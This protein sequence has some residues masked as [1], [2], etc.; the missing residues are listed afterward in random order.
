MW[1]QLLLPRRAVLPGR[2]SCATPPIFIL[3]STGLF[4]KSRM[5][6]RECLPGFLANRISSR[7]G[8]LCDGED[9]SR[10]AGAVW[11]AAGTAGFHDSLPC[12]CPP[13]RLFMYVP[14]LI[15]ATGLRLEGEAP[16]RD[17]HGATRCH[18]QSSRA[19]PRISQPL[20]SPSPPAARRSVLAPS[21]PGRPRGT[22]S[23]WGRA[24]LSSSCRFIP[25]LRVGPGATPRLPASPGSPRRPQGP[26]R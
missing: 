9:W 7:L 6:P 13:G 12:R 1:P 24:R 15:P 5:N 19:G 14:M 23:A 8:R 25:G 18:H 17:H 2:L 20:F 10:V 3:I 16:L 11:S 4:V 26:V 21:R 22:R